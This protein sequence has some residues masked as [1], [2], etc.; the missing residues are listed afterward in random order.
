M[1]DSFDTLSEN[2]DVDTG[3]ME[4]HTTDILE[5]TDV[6]ELQPEYIEGQLSDAGADIQEAAQQVVVNPDNADQ[7]V[8]DLGD[9]LSSRAEDL[10]QAVDEEAISN[11]VEENTDLTGQ[12]A[13]EATQNVVQGL[14]QSTQQAQEALDNAGNQLDQLRSDIDQGVQE[15]QATADEAT[16]VSAWSLVGLFVGHI[17][18]AIVSSLGGK[19]GSNLVKQSPY[20]EQA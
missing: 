3:E 15:L 19:L 2:V 12:E 17:V 9:Q 10:G 8:N 1:T 4:Q 18:M 6:E 20:E 16:S 13:E 14:E 11:S 5:G 7:I